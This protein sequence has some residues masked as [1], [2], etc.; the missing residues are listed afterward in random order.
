MR[1]G[2]WLTSIVVLCCLALAET[3]GTRL[4]VKEYRLPRVERIVENQVNGFWEPG[5]IEFE[6]YVGTPSREFHGVSDETLSESVGI[7]S[8]TQFIDIGP[9]HKG[10]EFEL[11]EDASGNVWTRQSRHWDRWWDS[12][13]VYSLV[14]NDTAVYRVRDCRVTEEPMMFLRQGHWWIETYNYKA[15]EDTSSTQTSPG[16]GFQVVADGEV[17]SSKYGCSETSDYH[18]VGDKPFFLFRRDSLFGWNYDGAETV[19]DFD[20]LFHGG[21]CEYGCANP[22]FYA[23]DFSFYARRDSV[24]YLVVGTLK[25]K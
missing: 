11:L 20:S 8:M 15:A 24:W 18:Y 2:F 16:R 10:E 1:L 3:P 12:C 14:R 13:W 21:C 9:A 4:D 5:H 22:R 23:D 17:L 19:T 25:D 6:A 7:D